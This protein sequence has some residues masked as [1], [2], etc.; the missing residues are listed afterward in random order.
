MLLGL[1]C[2]TDIVLHQVYKMVFCLTDGAEQGYVICDGQSSWE[3]K[4]GGKSCKGKDSILGK[5]C[6]LSGIL[7]CDRMLT[8]TH[9][10]IIYHNAHKHARMHTCMRA[11]THNWITAAASQCLGS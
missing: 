3:Y 7:K 4:S 9:K 5:W 2:A 1:C 10:V 8:D 11:H 6:V